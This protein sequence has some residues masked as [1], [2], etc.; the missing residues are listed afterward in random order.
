MT[1]PFVRHE[2]N[3]EVRTPIQDRKIPIDHLYKVCEVHH[4]VCLGI[5]ERPLDIWVIIV[6]EPEL[7]DEI[8]GVLF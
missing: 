1:Q 3:V 4:S 7:V 8:R 6:Y 2:V 5:I